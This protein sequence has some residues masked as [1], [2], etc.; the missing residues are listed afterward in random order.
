MGPLPERGH[1]G[2]VWPPASSGSRT[3]QVQGQDGRGA[4]LPPA[5][6]VRGA[7]RFSWGPRTRGQ[8]PEEGKAL[9]LLEHGVCPAFSPRS[10]P[11]LYLNPR[12]SLRRV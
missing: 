10:C 3:R 2:S 7:Q 1:R 6:C 9:P 11:G 4:R 8:G 5:G 12:A